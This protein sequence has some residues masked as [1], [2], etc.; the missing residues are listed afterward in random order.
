VAIAMVNAWWREGLK[1]LS[2]PNL[3]GANLENGQCHFEKLGVK[4]PNFVIILFQFTQIA[5]SRPLAVRLTPF[6][7]HICALHTL[8]LLI[9]GM[10]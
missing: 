7:V 3:V 6:Q 8:L 4:I 1:S 9:T 2:G 5:V 10:H